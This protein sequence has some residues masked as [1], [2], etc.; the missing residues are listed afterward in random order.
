MSGY[1]SLGLGAAQY[2]VVATHGRW[3]G[4]REQALGN[5]LSIHSLG[6]ENRSH[7]PE[8]LTGNCSNPL[9]WGR[10]QEIPL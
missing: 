6:C 10:R 2:R 9:L 8:W 7:Q 1:F 5:Q 4:L 3:Q